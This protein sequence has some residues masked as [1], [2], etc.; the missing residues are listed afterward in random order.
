M[1]RF[2]AICVAALLPIQ[3][4]WANIE[5]IKPGENLVVDGIPPISADIARK[6]AAYTEFRTSRIVGWHPTRREILISTRLKNANQI[7]RVSEPGA[8][9]EPITDFKD[10]VNAAHYQP[11]QG[12]FFLFEKGN[13]GDEAFQISRLDL[14]TRSVTPISPQDVRAG[15]PAWNHEGNRVVFT[16]QKLDKNNPGKE[17][18]TELHLVDPMNPE[19][20]KVI[21]TFEGGHWDSFRWSVDDKKLLFGEFVSINES[22]LW[23]MDLASGERKRINAVNP[24]EQVSYSEA[25]FAKD[26]KGVYAISDRDNEFRHLVF[27]DLASDKEEVLT[28]NLK[29]DVDEFAISKKNN[30]IAFTTNEDGAHV[31]RFFDLETNK[32]LPRPALVSGTISGLRWNKQ[33]D[34][35]GFNHASSRSAG[36]VFSWNINTSKMT[37]WTNGVAPDINVTEF[38][39]PKLIRWKSFDGL[40]VSGLL[41]LPPAEK[42]SG[43]RP[44]I[45]NIHGGP[46][47]QAKAG[48]IGRGNYFVNELGIAVIFPNVRGS[49]GYGKSF[50]KLDNGKRRED[51]VKDIG[52]LLDWIK[53]QP[54]LDSRRVLVMGG[55][56]GG[57]MSLAVAARYAERIAGAINSVGISNFVTFLNN[58]ETYRRDQRRVEYGDERDPAMRVFLEKISPLTHAD[59]IRKPLF[60]IQGRNDPRVPYTEAE[61]IVARLKKHKTPV[62]FLMANDEGHGFAK[63]SN[64]DFLF[65]AQVKFMQDTLLK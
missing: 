36:D 12:D 21:A 43:K 11:K 32:E 48:F 17:A 56:Y 25:R 45:I 64:A 35:L 6:A 49:S 23:T 13:G 60:V 59:K 34:E 18:Q 44:V 53:E 62:W 2:P 51:S 40:A 20:D 58:T 27:I 22:H 15:T 57:Y 39:E 16:T 31:L 38:V 5:V 42:F 4:A 30:R 52:A 41:Y 9:P 33:G 47:S 26:G 61:Q 3:L 14:E 65:Y 10:P 29:W 24:G 46:E 8:K 28:A 1:R 63:K 7:H 50:L 37:R 19:S 54:D 55:S